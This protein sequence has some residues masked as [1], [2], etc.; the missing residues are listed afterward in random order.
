MTQSEKKI[1][2]TASP[3]DV[4][5][6]YRPC[7]GQIQ[8]LK[9]RDNK[10]LRAV[11]VRLTL[12][13]S[14]ALLCMAIFWLGLSHIL[15]P[16][17][18]PHRSG[19]AVFML[20][21]FLFPNLVH[22]AA[23]WRHSLLIAADFGE[24]GK[25]SPCERL[26]LLTARK[27]VASELGDAKPYIDVMH[28]QIGDSLAE[29]EREVMAAIEQIG[30]LIGQ[31]DQQR[32]HIARSVKS[33]RELTE[34]TQARIDQ[35]REIVTAIATEL[36]EEIQE[37]R[38]N[39]T[40]IQN[41]TSE[42]CAL[43]PLINVITSIAKQTNM[44]ALNAEIEAARAGSAGRGFAVVANEVRQLAA[45]SNKAAADISERINSTCRKVQAE[46]T[47]SQ[48]TL[49]QHEA[50]SSAS[51]LVAD[52]GSMQEEFSRNG[53]LLLEV[54]SEVEQNYAESVNH[55]SDAL[56]HIQ[57]QD[58]MRQRM[59]HVQETLVE[60]SD[61]LRMLKEN[62]ETPG[63]DGTIDQTFKQMLAAHLSQYHMASQTMT[64]L[65]VSGS[66]APS[67]DLSRPAIELF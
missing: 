29:S 59:G 31:S 19:V 15:G 12:T 56:G 40:R 57:F 47:E 23:S 60:M 11:R 33:G 50:N 36:Q 10:H 8:G 18:M 43:A 48:A 5:E 24:I 20:V 55:L 63:W 25:M 1:R 13:T 7:P 52:L 62:P 21:C 46:L 28:D 32:E 37:M 53:K 6:K 44:L 26:T 4:S 3:V 42:V 38:S 64:H 66:S 34:S 39:F 9:N 2:A 22:V 27:V 61:H 45:L 51:S 30:S 35:N 16:A 67:G 49:Q 65:A 14:F 58:V 41:L 54:I 17:L